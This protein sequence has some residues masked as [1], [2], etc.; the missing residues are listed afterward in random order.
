MTEKEREGL[1][2][3]A[4]LV[5]IFYL[6]CTGKSFPDKSIQRFFIKRKDEKGN[7]LSNNK[8]QPYKQ[9]MIAFKKWLNK[10]DGDGFYNDHVN[11]VKSIGCPTQ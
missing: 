4:E 8:Y 11:Q 6:P 3:L 2:Q 9:I 7:Y 10:R 5:G 1:M